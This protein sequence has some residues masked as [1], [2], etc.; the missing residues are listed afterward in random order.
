MHNKIISTKKTKQREQRGGKEE[1]T[2]IEREKRE[3][4]QNLLECS[5]VNYK[6]C[7]AKK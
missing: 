3:E 2:D 1:E 4:E 5:H 7:L 6:Q